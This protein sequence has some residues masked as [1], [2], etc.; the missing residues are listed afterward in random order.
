MER[1]IDLWFKASKDGIS[2]FVHHQLKERIDSVSE[3]SWSNFYTALLGNTVWAAAAFASGGTAFAI[4]M[5]GVAIAS[6]PTVPQ[7]GKSDESLKVVEEQM[8]QYVEG[9][10]GQLN[11]QLPNSAAT[12]LQAHPKIDLDQAIALWLKDSFKPD[13]VKQPAG[14][15]DR[16]I[17]H[18]TN[19][20]KKMEKDAEYALDLAKQMERQYVTVYTDPNVPKTKGKYQ[21]V[22][23][24]DPPRP[25][26]GY[27]SRA[28]T[29]LALVEVDSGNVYDVRPKLL[30]VRFLK[31]IP[32]ENQEIAMETQKAIAGK[33]PTYSWQIVKGLDDINVWK[34]LFTKIT[35]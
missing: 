32:A 24:V 21:V 20:R 3:G 10:H 29:S 6:K 27:S 14:K 2:Q 4:S 12:L 1:Q 16:P 35:P 30:D 15:T 25:P 11:K 19:V 7:K 18:V 28:T 23:W 26:V 9:I 34:K 8:H 13:M 22:A 31:W 17:V 33:V 5:V